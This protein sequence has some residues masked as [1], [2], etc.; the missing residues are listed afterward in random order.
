MAVKKITKRWLTGSF[1]IILV[2]VVVMVAA[3]SIGVKNYYYNGARQYVLSRAETVTERLTA[4]SQDTST[5]FMT[6][7]RRL[8]EKFDYKD[9]MELMAVQD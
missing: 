2:I 8:V 5:D 6:E 7:V 1:G 9:K 3:V 4:Y